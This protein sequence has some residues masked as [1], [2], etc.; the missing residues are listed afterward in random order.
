MLTFIK[1]KFY[2]LKQIHTE[3]MDDIDVRMKS[4]F[5]QVELV[6]DLCIFK[7]KIHKINT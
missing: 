4:D 2:I 6:C 1:C 7:P 3:F 5:Y